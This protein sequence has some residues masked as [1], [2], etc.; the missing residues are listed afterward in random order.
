MMEDKIEKTLRGLKDFQAKTVDYVFDQLYNIG[1]SKM[2]IADEVGLGKTIVAKGIIVK[3]FSKFVPTSKKP[4]FKV[5]YICSNQALARQNLSK[6][7]FTEL[8]E[9]IDYSDEDDRVTALAYQLNNGQ[10]PVPFQI[11]AFTPATSF[12]DRTHAG[13]ADERILLLLLI[14]SHPELKPFRMSFL[15]LMKV[16]ERMKVKNW[17]R[18]VQ[19]LDNQQ[20]QANGRKIRPEIFASFHKSLQKK[21]GKDDL[22]KT[23]SILGLAKKLSYIELLKIVGNQTINEKTYPDLAYSKELISDLRFRLSRV[24]IQF[25]DADIFILDE[26]QR[27]K[28]LIAKRK[29]EDEDSVSR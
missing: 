2:L 3:A 10:K 1:Q 12:D 21:V 19:E 24:C 11:K 27:Y 14:W 29:S 4:V 18:R 16:N 7:N 20:K 28:N 22:P 9:A 5:V 23:F 25:L 17:Q 13:K 8:K 15:W 26:F 6:L